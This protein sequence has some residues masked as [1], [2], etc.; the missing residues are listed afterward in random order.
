MH[1]ALRLHKPDVQADLFSVHDGVDIRFRALP[2]RGD[3][4]YR[5]RVP[6]ESA[7]F[8]AKCVTAEARWKH[9]SGR[10]SQYSTLQLSFS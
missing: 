3:V 1:E 7:G 2:T 6:A 9:R 5:C 4:E 10:V 8:L